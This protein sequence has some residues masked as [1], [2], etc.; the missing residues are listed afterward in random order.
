MIDE[1][2]NSCEELDVVLEQ[3]LCGDRQDFKKSI[4]ENPVLSPSTIPRP[5]TVMGANELPVVIQEPVRFRNELQMMVRMQ[6]TQGLPT[7]EEFEEVMK[8]GS[9]IQIAI[10]KNMMMAAKGDIKAFQYI[11]D[12]VLGKPVN[13]TNNVNLT[14][15]YE[16]ALEQLNPDEKIEPDKK[17]NIVSEQ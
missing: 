2:K 13:Q 5:I 14:V 15:T 7:E 12:R 6:M 4:F 9:M 17:F 1:L 8:S 11:M 3:I 10:T 16:Q